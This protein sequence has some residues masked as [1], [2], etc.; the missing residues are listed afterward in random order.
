MPAA[1]WFPAEAGQE[2]DVYWYVDGGHYE[3]W[4]FGMGGTWHASR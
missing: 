2:V 3:G 4:C 1:I